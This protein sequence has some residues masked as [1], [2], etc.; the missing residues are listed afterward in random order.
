MKI[1]TIGFVVP[2]FLV[3]C[4]GQQGKVCPGLPEFGAPEAASTATSRSISKDAKAVAPTAYAKLL[5]DEAAADEPQKRELLSDGQRRSTL[6]SDADVHTYGR[7]GALWRAAKK[8]GHKP[9][10]DT[11]NKTD[12]VIGGALDCRW[13]AVGM[14]VRE[15]TKPHCTATLI[16]PSTLLTAAHCVD[17]YV[18]TPEVFGAFFGCGWDESTAELSPVGK[19][20][21]PE[22]FRRADKSGEHDVAVACL[23][24]RQTEIRPRLLLR[25]ALPT[26]AYLKAP[27]SFVGFGLTNRQDRDSAGYRNSVDMRVQQ[28][29][30]QIFTYGDEHQGTCYGDSGGPAFLGVFLVGVTSIVKDQCNRLGASA[31]VDHNLDFID[32]RIRECNALTKK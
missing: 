7:L 12:K 11:W 2:V 20:W 16:G 19:V 13:N 9:E 15:R 29:L 4:V 17:E 14:L 26:E 25:T 22:G 6:I 1:V 21:C 8:P 3:G 31:R 10:L 27:L 28:V 23:S 24:Q 5:N 30:P 32:A 18:N